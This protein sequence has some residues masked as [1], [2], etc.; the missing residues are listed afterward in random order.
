MNLAQRCIAKITGIQSE[1]DRLAAGCKNLEQQ[2]AA[3]K[4]GHDA[5]RVEVEALRSDKADLEQGL[6]QIAAALGID[7]EAET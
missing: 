2:L 3:E 6:A 4:K 5:A 7:P 1:V